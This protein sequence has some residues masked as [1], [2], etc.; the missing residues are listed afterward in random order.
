MVMAKRKERI[1]VATAI[2][3]DPSRTTKVTELSRPVPHGPNGFVYGDQSSFAASFDLSC[4][5]NLSCHNLLPQQ[6]PRYVATY[7]WIDSI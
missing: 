4:Y 3:G 2:I 1:L 6:K 5:L 7:N